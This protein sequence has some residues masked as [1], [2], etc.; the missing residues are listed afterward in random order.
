MT[1]ECPYYVVNEQKIF[2][3]FDPPHLIKAARNNLLNNII[4]SGDK[5]MSWQ[6]IEELYE[7][8]KEN[9]NRLVPKLAQDTHINPNN[10]QQYESEICCS[11]LKFFCSFCY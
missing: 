11:S 4:K 6:H 3:F 7:I 5:T 1:E 8:D 2:Y 9:I 10:F